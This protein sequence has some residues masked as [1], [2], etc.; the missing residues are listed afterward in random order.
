MNN[1]GK[2]ANVLLQADHATMNLENNLTE[3]IG[4]VSIYRYIRSCLEALASNPR[5][6]YTAT[7]N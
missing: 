3:T 7:C 4:L 5:R 2:L 1:K 6:M